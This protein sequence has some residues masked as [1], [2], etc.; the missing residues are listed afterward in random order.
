MIIKLVYQDSGYLGDVVGVAEMS[1]NLVVIQVLG[2]LVA[3]CSDE[4]TRGG[5]GASQRHS[6]GT[7]HPKGAA[8]VVEEDATAMTN[9]VNIINC[10]FVGEEEDQAQELT[11][12]ATRC[13]HTRRAK[14]TTCR[15]RLYGS[16]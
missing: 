11:M 9:F 16:R 10:L 4:A 7:C 14:T 8:V 13:S 5:G 15:L 1:V 12:D 2:P 6:L 3:R